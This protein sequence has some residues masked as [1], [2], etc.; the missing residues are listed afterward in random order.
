MVT[1]NFPAKAA[2]QVD[3]ATT[4]GSATAGGDYTA[5]SGTM[6]IGPGRTEATL[7]VAILDD[8]STEPDE[9]FVVTLGNPAG[10]TV[11]DGKAVGTILDDDEPE[12]TLTI[13]DVV[14]TEGE[15]ETA[16]FT[17]VLSATSANTVT[18]RYATSDGS[19]T[20]GADYVSARG[21]LVDSR[22]RSHGRAPVALID[23]AT[24]E[25]NETLAV[26]LS[27]PTGAVTED[28]EGKG[29]IIDNDEPPAIGIG[30]AEATEGSDPEASFRS[31]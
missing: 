15:H 24:D 4:D 29:T 14:V 9:T 18:V 28:G 31:R 30:D 3:Y 25:P 27:N 10:A 21:T 13:Q 17:V 8:G 7:R 22:R 6:V 23:D 19:A 20:A 16:D 12:P 1:L 2:I 5:A 11:D 26:I